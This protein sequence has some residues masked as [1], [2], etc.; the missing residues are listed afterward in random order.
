MA[1]MTNVVIAGMDSDGTDG[2]T[3][4][5][6]ALADGDMVSRARFAGL[7]LF[8]SLKRH[9]VT[10]VLQK[11]GDAVYTGTTGTNVNDLKFILILPGD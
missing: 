1:G 4:L 7:N 3:E 2:P 9:D 8:D 6:G 11:L 10:P 5:A